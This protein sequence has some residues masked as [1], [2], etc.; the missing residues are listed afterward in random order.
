ML[1]T[2]SEHWGQNSIPDPDQNLGFSC[3][4]S[5][6]CKKVIYSR[7]NGPLNIQQYC[8]QLK[9][10]SRN[11]KKERRKLSRALKKKETF[12][13]HNPPDSKHYLHYVNVSVLIKFSQKTSDFT[14]IIV[15]FP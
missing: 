2:G 13:K 8:Y 6:G 3:I 12:E 9:V 10:P 4:F 11:I 14:L 7:I 15:S 5:L 1:S